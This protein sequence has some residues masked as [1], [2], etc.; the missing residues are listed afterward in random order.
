[1]SNLY[2]ARSAA[3]RSVDALAGRPL[4]VPRPAGPVLDI[5]FIA[6]HHQQVFKSVAA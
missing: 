2:V 4:L 6:W 1:V 5:A 3:G